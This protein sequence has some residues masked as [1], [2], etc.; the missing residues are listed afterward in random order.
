LATLVNQQVGA[1]L[2]GVDSFLTSR[3]EKILALAMRHRLP[4]IY[5]N[6]EFVLAGGLMSYHANFTD[7]YRVMGSYTGRIM[8]GEKAADLPVQEG[9]KVE[10]MINLKTAKALGITVPPTLLARADEVIE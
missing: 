3:R 7:M 9:S 10:L 8:K 5:Q 6:R 4:T 1:L 2:V